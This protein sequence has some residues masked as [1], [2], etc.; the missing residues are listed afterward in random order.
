MPRSICEPLV[1]QVP[2][3]D[4]Q[5]W[6]SSMNVPSALKR[7]TNAPKV[8]GEDGSCG[9]A[10]CPMADGRMAPEART[11]AATSTTASRG[12]MLFIRKRG[13]E[14]FP[15]A[16][17]RKRLPTPFSLFSK[18]QA[19][20]R[21]LVAKVDEAVGDG[22]KGANGSSQNLRFGERPERL[23]RCRARGRARRFPA[24]SAAGR[25]RA[26]P[27]RRDTDRHSISPRP[28]SDRRRESSG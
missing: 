18:I 19:H 15:L 1:L 26:S 28:S 8:I 27:N 25:R 4:G 9:A 21:V 17:S 14:S 13:R 20:E 22:R 6:P 16:L 2:G 10:A 12:I 5:P 11:P 7:T 24:R 3:M 23:R